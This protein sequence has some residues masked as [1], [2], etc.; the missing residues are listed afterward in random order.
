MKGKID[1]FVINHFVITTV[2]IHGKRWNFGLEITL[3]TN[4]DFEHCGR[5]SKMPF[6]FLR[7]QIC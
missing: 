6:F 2:H 7:S 3:R 4:L 5:V 1:F